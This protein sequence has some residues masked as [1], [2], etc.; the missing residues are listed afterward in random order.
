MMDLSTFK[1]QKGVS[2]LSKVNTAFS[3]EYLSL[4]NKENRILTDYE[5]RL[6]PMISKENINYSEWKTR[7]E[8][9]NRFINYLRTKNQKLTI[10]DIGCGNG[11]FS[12]KINELKHNVIGLDINMQELEQANRVFNQNSKNNIQ[13]VYASVF[14]SNIPFS[15]KF[16]IITLNASVQYFPDFKLLMSNLKLFLKPN[17]E[18][19]ILDSPFY[20]VSEIKSAKKRTLDYYTNMG[21]PEM[22][23]NYF[24]HD[25]KLISNFEVLYQPKKAIFSKIFGK[26]D[27]PFLW[28]RLINSFGDV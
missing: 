26:K 22:T 27:S 10:L 8:T 21:F 11:W 15:N 2:I 3:D 17:G 23:E 14:Q 19:H 28:L 12:N 5:V 4:R 25:E 13:F 18:I 20:N 1:K 24:H 7:K 16:D 6:L 9:A